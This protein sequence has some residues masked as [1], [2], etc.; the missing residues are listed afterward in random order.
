METKQP[1]HCVQHLDKRYIQI[2]QDYMM[3]C[4]FSEVKAAILWILEEAK[5]AWTPLTL[6]SFGPVAPLWELDESA[7]T[8]AKSELLTAGY[9]EQ[10]ADGGTVEY[11]LNSP[12]VQQA[13]SDLDYSALEQ[14]DAELDFA[15][16][17]ISVE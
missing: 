12:A 13:L 5:G 3:L 15:N 2:N 6:D 11:Q 17:D 16:L 1:Y 7:L 14:L 4:D 9:I 8:T 10:H